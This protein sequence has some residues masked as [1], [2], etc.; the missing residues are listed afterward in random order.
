MNKFF[1][2]I[3]FAL[4][5]LISS[6]TFA[7]KSEKQTLILISTSFGDIKIKL[8]NETPKHRDNFIKLV[9]N[10]TL[11]ETLFHRVIKDFMI[12]GGDPDSKNAEKG[13]ALGEGGLGYTIPAEFNSS[14][15]HK[16]GVLAGARESDDVNP[17]K[18]S[19]SCQFYIVQGRT[20]T[21]AE[22]EKMLK[23]K[24]AKREDKIEYTEEQFKTYETIG[25]TPHLDMDYTI[26]GE[27]VE[28]LDVV[29]KIAEVKKDKRD[30][31]IE[32]VKMT[33]KIVKK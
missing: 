9:K 20:F 1:S 29:D 2:C 25:G 10:G 27:V 11:N 33:I 3:I 28:G 7:Q 32:D 17:E 5:L 24:N 4:V 26:F 23:G 12:Q 14:L 8:Y 30:R 18:A 22:I 13:V 21:R 31:P 16:K 6:N 15:I 19:S